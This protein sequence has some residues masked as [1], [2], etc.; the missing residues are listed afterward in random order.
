MKWSHLSLPALAMLT[1]SGCQSGGGPGTAGGIVIGVEV[2]PHQDQEFAMA[3]TGFDKAHNK[4]DGMFSSTRISFLKGGPLGTSK[5]KDDVCYFKANAAA[6]DYVLYKLIVQGAPSF[7]GALTGQR[8]ATE[9]DM[10][11]GTYVFHVSPGKFTY[12]G[13]YVVDADLGTVHGTPFETHHPESHI[14]E[15]GE[16]E[17]SISYRMDLAATEAAT[18]D[19][20][21]FPTELVPSEPSA[22]TFTP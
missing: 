2:V 3:L 1:L 11:K 13:T 16:S 14:G 4:A 8:A 18:K 5:C 20:K 19:F 17:P 10:S 12:G 6:G 7:G 22:T 15:H 21:G 9:R